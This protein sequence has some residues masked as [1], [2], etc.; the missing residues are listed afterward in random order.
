MSEIHY[1]EEVASQMKFLLDLSRQKIFKKWQEQTET[2]YSQSF[3][4]NKK[5]K[6]S[7]GWFITD[8]T[9]IIDGKIAV[10][11]L[12]EDS[13]YLYCGFY[14]D[15]PLEERRCQD[16]ATNRIMKI[17]NQTLSNEEK[18]FQPNNKEELFVSYSKI[19]IDA[20]SK[21][22][23]DFCKIVDELTNSL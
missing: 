2:K 17:L 8:V 15:L 7:K 10:V 3:M 19:D 18:E 12:G 16:D 1:V 20:Y 5:T 9:I 22:Y 21:A 11:Y 6:E 13:S 4:P 23:I 14:F